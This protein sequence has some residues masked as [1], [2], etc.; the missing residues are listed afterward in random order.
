MLSYSRM[1]Q[2]RNASNSL[3]YHNAAIKA[4]LLIAVLTLALSSNALA[5]GTGAAEHDLTIKV[6]NHSVG[7]LGYSTGTVVCY[8]FGNFWVPLPVFVVAPVM[9]IVPTLALIT[10]V[11]NLRAPRK[12][13]RA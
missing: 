4:L 12:K 1:S 13:R 7:F 3:G 8:G 6:S 10:W 11:H 9:V 2:L 5:L